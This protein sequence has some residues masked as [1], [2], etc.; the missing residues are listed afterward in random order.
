MFKLSTCVE[1]LSLDMHVLV[2]SV[3][4]YNYAQNKIVLLL[5]F[6]DQLLPFNFSSHVQSVTQNLLMM[7]MVKIQASDTEPTGIL[8]DTLVKPKPMNLLFF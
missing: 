4:L 1:N 6:F 5:T 2:N 7:G 3:Y 8:K